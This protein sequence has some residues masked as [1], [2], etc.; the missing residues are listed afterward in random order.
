[1]TTT[2]EV[3]YATDFFEQSRAGVNAAAW[4]A[5]AF[6]STLR[7]V[8]VCDDRAQV[9]LEMAPGYVG[10]AEWIGDFQEKI[11]REAAQRIEGLCADIQS[12]DLSVTHALFKGSPK[13]SLKAYIEENE[14]KIS[15]VT[16]TKRR[17]SFFDEFFFGSVSHALVQRSPCPTLVFP[18]D[19]NLEHWTP[20][21]CVVAMSLED[22]SDQALKLA[23]GIIRRS[24][25]HISLLHTV[26]MSESL[27]NSVG[28]DVETEEQVK[29]QMR[30][31]ALDLDIAPEKVDVHIRFG[32]VVESVSLFMQ[33]TRGDLLVVGSHAQSNLKRSVLGSIAS[34]L[35]QSS[36]YPLLVVKS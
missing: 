13:E 22:G 12:P 2:N 25:G 27:A 4:F 9:Q 1:M 36:R 31:K 16:L 17:R 30:K 23:A 15:L 35:A 14:T 26:E 7:I 34:T 19:K 21:H 6:S 11:L 32:S 29:T 28:L 3:V 24:G 5:R 10:S 20:T 18:D 8:H 33:E